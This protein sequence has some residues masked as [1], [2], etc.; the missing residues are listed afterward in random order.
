MKLGRVLSI[1]GVLAAVAAVRSVRAD[2]APPP[3][4]EGWSGKGQVGFLS[5]HGNTSSDSANAKL[6]LTYLEDPWKYT[7]SLLGFYGESGDIV[8]AERLEGQLQ[9]NYNINSRLFAFGML[10][11]TH[12]EFNGFVYEADAAVGLGYKVLDTPVD[13]LSAQIGPGYQR[14]RPEELVK[15]ADGAVIQR[16]PGDTESGAIVSVGVNYE[17]DFNA[18]TKLIDKLLIESG[19][20][21]TS[22][23]NDLSIQVKMSAKLALA[24]GWTIQNNS[25]PPAGLKSEDTSETL[26]LVYSF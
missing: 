14:L 3:T 21:N 26:S 7:F 10:H 17:H 25:K 18:S 2:D 11:Y 8:S 6:D 1:V 24:A 16:I 13:K 12:D 20:A 22:V 15:D 5:T 19:S 9:S 4:P 23:G